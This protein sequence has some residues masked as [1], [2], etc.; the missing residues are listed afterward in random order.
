MQ[1]G[2]I[3]DDLRQLVH[4]QVNALEYNR[5]N[6]NGYHFQTANLESSH[7]LAATSNNGVVTSVED[8]SGVSADYYDV[9]PYFS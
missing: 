9:A 7:P 2:N 8:A 4:G 3:S 6:I 1:D 5:Y